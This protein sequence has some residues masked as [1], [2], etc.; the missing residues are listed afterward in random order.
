MKRG[1]SDP[2]DSKVI[3]EYAYEKMYKLELSK[4]PDRKL[5]K[6]EKLF[7]RRNLL[8]RQKKALQVSICEQKKILH[9]DVKELL[10][11]QNKEK[12]DLYVDQIRYLERMIEELLTM[13][14]EIKKNYELSKSVIGI[15]PISAGLMICQTNN[16]KDFTSSRKYASY[17][18]IAPF[19]NQSGIR[20]GKSK[21]SSKANKKLKAVLSN[22]VQTAI[23]YDP[24]LKGYAE[25]LKENN[26]E[27]GIVYNNVKNK[28]IQR[29]FIVVKRGTPYVKLTYQ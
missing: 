27:D 11:M 2:A 20:S 6:V 19:P 8:V 16:F 5:E 26:K 4:M 17:I 14:E 10:E 22:G 3:C 23:K 15:G 25:R 1:K 13:D 24:F 18:G 29:V 28:L 12:I 21:V 7:T 9:N